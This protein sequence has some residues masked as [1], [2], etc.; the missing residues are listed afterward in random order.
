MY[1]DLYVNISDTFKLV[2]IKKKYVN[3]WHIY[4]TAFRLH[5]FIC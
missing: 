3:F 5:E 1:V 2:M 4:N